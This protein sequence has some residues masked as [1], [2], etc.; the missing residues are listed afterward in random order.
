MTSNV[1]DAGGTMD[2]VQALLGQKHPSSPR[3]YLHPN[4]VRLRDAVERV[5]S[6]RL[7]TEGTDR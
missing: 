7:D 6:L 4:P 5:P 1:V 2:E 3:P